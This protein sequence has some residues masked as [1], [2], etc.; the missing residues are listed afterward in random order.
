MAAA[1]SEKEAMVDPF[2][3]EALQNPRHRLTRF[4]IDSP[5]HL[6]FHDGVFPQM[7]R[8]QP[9]ISYGHPLNPAMTSTNAP[10]YTEWPI[11]T[12]TYAQTLHASDPNHFRHQN[13]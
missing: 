2:L 10:A 8:T 12:M 9:N 7:P 1:M 13:P 11:V 6:P 3:V 5:I 4:V